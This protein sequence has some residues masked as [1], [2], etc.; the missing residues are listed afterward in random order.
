MKVFMKHNESTDAE[1]MQAHYADINNCTGIKTRAITLC[2]LP[3]LSKMP[4]FLWSLKTGGFNAGV[5]QVHHLVD[6][7]VVHGWRLGQQRGNDRYRDGHCV[8]L[9][10]CRHYWNHCIRDPGYQEACAD[11]H[12][13]LGEHK[14]H[15]DWKFV[16]EKVPLRVLAP[17]SHPP[18]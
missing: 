9:T 14:R 15:W 11:Q 4:A 16:L 17:A 1:L 18:L 10:K 2:V 13:H 12:R 7:G 3:W 5:F 6:D 8:R